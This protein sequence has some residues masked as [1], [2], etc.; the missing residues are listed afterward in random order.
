MAMR[1]LGCVLMVSELSGSYGPAG[2]TAGVLTLA[3]AAASPG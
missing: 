3:Q 1:A 2:V